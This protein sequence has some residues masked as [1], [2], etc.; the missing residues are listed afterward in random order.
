[1]RLIWTMEA[2]LG[3]DVGTTSA[4]ALLLGLDGTVLGEGR[5][6]YGMVRVGQD[7]YE[8][9][10]EDYWLGIVSATQLA[11]SSAPSDIRVLALGLSSQA[12]TTIPVDGTGEPLC[13]AISWMDHRGRRYFSEIDSVISPAYVHNTSGW[14]LTAA[15]SIMHIIRLRHEKPDLYNSARRFLFANDFLVHRLTEDYCT[16]PSDAGITGLYNLRGKKWDETLLNVAGIGESKLS[17]I[18]PSGYPIGRLSRDSANCLG[19]TTDTLVIN[20]AHDQYC[21]ALGAGAITPG[22]VLISSGTAWVILMVLP[23]IESAFR[24]DMAVSSHAIDGLWGALGSAGAV[25]KGMSWFSEKVLGIMDLVDTYKWIEQAVSLSV[26]GANGL[27]F[28]AP[29]V[30]LSEGAISGFVNLN[31]DH[32]LNDMARSI[33]ES[34]AYEVKRCSLRLEESQTAFSKAIMVGGSAQSSMA[35]QLLADVLGIPIEV[36]VVS[37][38]ASL[39]AAIIAGLGAKVFTHPSEGYLLDRASVMYEPNS[40]NVDIYAREY[41]DYVELVKKCRS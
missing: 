22:D 27:V 8:Q 40:N 31:I 5:H 6:S 19:L 21:A 25:G 12:G 3:I 24:T 17:E 7:G 37:E 34:A 10:P 16:D 20:G 38:A 33:M 30:G 35:T 41:T 13:N 9:D 11:L 18:L 4:K 15:S 26:P 28:I 23:D 2:L 29:A 36:P 39:G 14:K 32:D 1:V